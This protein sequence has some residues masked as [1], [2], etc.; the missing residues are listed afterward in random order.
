MMTQLKKLSGPLSLLLFG[1]VFLGVGVGLLWHESRYS[2][3]GVT[4]DATVNIKRTSTSSRSGSR[5]D[6][7]QY[8]VTYSFTLDEPADKPAEIY[9]EGAVSFETWNALRQG[10]KVP[11]IYLRSDPTTNRPVEDGGALFPWIFAV[12]GGVL[13]MAGAGLAARSVLQNP[14]DGDV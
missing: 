12:V 13:S 5:T 9:G 2:S 4:T 1:L 8:Q 6:S 7:I 3:E 10:D 11:I 14:S